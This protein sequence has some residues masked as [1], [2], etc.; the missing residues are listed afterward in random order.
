MVIFLN[1]WFLLVNTV[2][3]IYNMVEKFWSLKIQPMSRFQ[4][5]STKKGTI[6]NDIFGERIIVILLVTPEVVLA[7]GQ[8]TSTPRNIILEE[9]GIMGMLR[10]I[11][12]SIQH[13][14]WRYLGVR[15]IHLVLMM[16]LCLV[17]LMVIL[18][19][20]RV[21]GSY[22]SP[23]MK[24]IFGLMVAI[25]RCLRVEMLVVVLHLVLLVVVMWT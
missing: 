1:I 24:L 8:S 4:A 18:E 12:I 22:T 23:P 11:R 13:S 7:I 19:L 17:L 2:T 9:I 14:P 6:I 3:A 10:N 5:N 21:L 15:M 16:V 25:S 20:V